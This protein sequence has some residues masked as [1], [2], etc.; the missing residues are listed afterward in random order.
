MVITT[1]CQSG[2]QYKEDI[3]AEVYP[4]SISFPDRAAER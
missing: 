2:K 3:N 4:G 1:L